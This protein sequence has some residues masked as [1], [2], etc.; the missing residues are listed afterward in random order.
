MKKAEA[1]KILELSQDASIDE[2]KKAFKNKAKSLHPDINKEPDAE[3][4]FKKVN[5]A[6]QAIE[7]ND[8]DDNQFVSYSSY[9]GSPFGIDLNDL[10]SGFAG[11]SAKRKWSPPPIDIKTNVSISFKE[12]VLGCKK[13]ITYKCDVA[14]EK[15][16]GEGHRNIDNGCKKCGGKGTISGNQGGVIFWRNCTACLGKIKYEDCKECIDGKIKSERTLSVSIKPGIQNK[17][18]LRLSRVGNFNNQ[19]MSDVLL[20][21]NIEPE[22]GLLIQDRDVITTLPL[23]LLEALTGCKKTVK[24]IDGDKEITIDAGK[25]NKEEI[26]LPRLGVGRYGNERVILQIEYPQNTQELIKFLEERKN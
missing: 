24:T 1:Y 11:T 23:S 13:S 9:G 3:A 21:I 2:A 19:M 5:E 10:F 7:K 8:F 15:C 22:N 14:C 25:K 26:V 12:A 4:K 20:E 6:Y 17:D 16:N 18:I